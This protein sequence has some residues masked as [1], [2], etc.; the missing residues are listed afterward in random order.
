MLCQ[1]VFEITMCFYAYIAIN[2]AVDTDKG[3]D[4]NLA[5]RSLFNEWTPVKTAK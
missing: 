3:V 5:I 4:E 1:S 2:D